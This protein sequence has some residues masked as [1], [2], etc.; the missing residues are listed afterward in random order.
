VDHVVHYQVGV[1]CFIECA[2]V[3]RRVSES[4][5]D[6]ERESNSRQKTTSGQ[7]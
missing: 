7:T 1:L 3:R 5:G 2:G 4:A 6:V